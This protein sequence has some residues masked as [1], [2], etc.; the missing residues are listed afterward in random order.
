[1][2][3]PAKLRR[4]LLFCNPLM[5]NPPRAIALKERIVVQ[6]EGVEAGIAAAFM[7]D[8]WRHLVEFVSPVAKIFQAER[9]W[10]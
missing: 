6:V 3:R 4:R 2:D 7:L 1:M 10:R 5:L 8:R 9:N